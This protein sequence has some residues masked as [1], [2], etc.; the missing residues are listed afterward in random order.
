MK[1]RYDYHKVNHFV[2]QKFNE[3]VHFTIKHSDFF[4]YIGINGLI[5]FLI[6]AR[7]MTIA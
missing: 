2:R 4:D 6:T 7:F 5:L 3:M 1:N